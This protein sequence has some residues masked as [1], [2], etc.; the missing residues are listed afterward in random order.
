MVPSVIG[1]TNV[2]SKAKLIKK[3]KQHSYLIHKR[4]AYYS[5]DKEYGKVS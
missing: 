2:Y 1:N 3:I 4:P 5:K